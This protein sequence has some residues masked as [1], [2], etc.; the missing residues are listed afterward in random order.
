MPS[1]TPPGGWLWRTAWLTAILTVGRP[2]HPYPSRRTERL[3]WPSARADRQMEWSFVGGRTLRIC[4]QTCR[5]SGA[6]DEHLLD[7]IFPKDIQSGNPGCK[8]SPPIRKGPG[9]TLFNSGKIPSYAIFFSVT[10]KLF[11]GKPK[12][13]DKIHW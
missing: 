8:A 12:L 2:L 1:A 7:L 3:I 6:S 5:R 13:W 9:A 11:V 10:L 4:V